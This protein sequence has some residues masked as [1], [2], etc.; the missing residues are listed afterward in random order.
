MNRPTFYFQSNY[1]LPV[2]AAGILFYTFKND[3]LYLYILHTIKG[4]LEDLGGKTESVDND[5]YETAA[6]E[7]DEESNSMFN[8]WGIRSLLYKSSSNHTVYLKESKYCLFIIPA[9]S[10][11]INTIPFVAKANRSTLNK[12]TEPIGSYLNWIK[13]IP[14]L[15]TKLHPR[16][17]NT[18]LYD[19]LNQLYP[20]KSNFY[21]NDKLNL[22]NR[23]SSNNELHNSTVP[24]SQRPV[25]SDDPREPRNGEYGKIRKCESKRRREMGRYP[26]SIG[27]SA[28]DNKR[29][30]FRRY[31]ADTESESFQENVGDKDEQ[32]KL[33]WDVEQRT[34]PGVQ[35]E[36]N[37]Q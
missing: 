36:P 16:L 27:N 11:C 3:E 17:Q 33:R 31:F 23:T 5:M 22:I 35:T 28:G 1:K 25:G 9:I 12:A 14:E 15:K 10:A 26:Y 32:W 30:K 34:N 18:V 13:F 29:R 24:K 20:G 6:R 2:R 7:A 37:S 8:R 19:F 4:V 21:L